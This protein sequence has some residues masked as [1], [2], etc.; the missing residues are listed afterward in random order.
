MRALILVSM[1]ASGLALTGCG[2]ADTL[3][4]VEPPAQPV[5]L[6]CTPLPP[7][8]SAVKRAGEQLT[9]DGKPFRVIGANTYY[10][11]QLYAYGELGGNN[12]A[13]AAEANE[14]LDHLVCL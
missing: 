10:L 3:G 13:A 6:P 11:Q 5:V 1:L 8:T 7:I 9:L 4:P 14:A 12:A 2:K